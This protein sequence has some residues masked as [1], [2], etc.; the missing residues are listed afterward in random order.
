MFSFSETEVRSVV[1]AG[2]VARELLVGTFVAQGLDRKTADE[3]VD[4]LVTVFEQV[5]RQVEDLP[6]EAQSAL[7]ASL[8][9]EVE[10]LSQEGASAEVISRAMRTAAITPLGWG[11]EAGQAALAIGIALTIFA[12]VV[13]TSFDYSSEHGL[14]ISSP[15]GLAPGIEQTITHIADV[16]SAA[17]KDVG[18]KTVTPAPSKKI[19]PPAKSGNSN[20]SKANHVSDLVPSSAT[21]HTVLMPSGDP[22]LRAREDA[23]LLAQVLREGLGDLYDLPYRDPKSAADFYWRRN[24]ATVQWERGHNFSLD[25]GI[26]PMKLLNGEIVY[27]VS[28]QIQTPTNV[29]A[30]ALNELKKELKGRTRGL[31]SVRTVTREVTLLNGADEIPPRWM[32][33]A[34]GIGGPVALQNQI[35]G[36]S[37]LYVRSEANE[38]YLLT[39]GHVLSGFGAVDP[40]GKSA[41]S[42]PD[43]DGVGQ[44]IGTVDQHSEFTQSCGQTGLSSDV[45]IGAI[46]L[47]LG[48]IPR[49]DQRNMVDSIH[50][51]FQI[52]NPDD[53]L[54]NTTV[55][56]AP[57]LT[58][59]A[60]A[61]V[62]AIRESVEMTNRRTMRCLRA[63][64]LI[65][66]MLDRKSPAPNG[67]SG[68][69]VY[70]VDNRPLGL[71]VAGADAAS[72]P[73]LPAGKSR[74]VIYIQPL[75]AYLSSNRWS[76]FP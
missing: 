17:I 44:K 69:L 52:A 48:N 25:T 35:V 58:A 2:V 56:K 26:I 76:L 39:A 11:K 22:A 19:A 75:G 36:T 42:P 55:Y 21:Q 1:A 51:K 29:K 63:D 41:W 68:C 27:R 61:T 53:M 33:M 47:D 28:V 18:S 23:E 14:T 64:G 65:V 73:E 6:H 50:L 49:A 10:R 62:I 3:R 34:P 60:K 24:G 57:S 9:W 40:V 45:D 37:G 46:K 67:E 32:R 70:D 54:F 30:P 43:I 59:R 20:I 16:V 66:A 12:K 7:I 4:S 71:V 72:R 38:A 8:K 13:G 5:G 31:V 74:P 15:A